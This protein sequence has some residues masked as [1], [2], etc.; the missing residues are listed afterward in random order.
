MGHLVPRSSLDHPAGRPIRESCL[1]VVS[2]H[3]LVK[4]VSN[5]H[6]A[7]SC[8]LSLT[9]FQR[10]R[11]Q[12]LPFSLPFGA[13]GALGSR[14][15]SDLG[16]YAAWALEWLWVQVLVLPLTVWV[17]LGDLFHQFV[18]QLLYLKIQVI[19]APTS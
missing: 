3:F 4:L 9:P 15:R 2:A 10:L 13:P 18:S 12:Y 6:G 14:H 11:R 8:R 5:L 16:Q 7:P 1:E 17:T 19:T